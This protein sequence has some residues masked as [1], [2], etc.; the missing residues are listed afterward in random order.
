M[1]RRCEVGWFM[2]TGTA[3]VDSDICTQPCDCL[4]VKRPQPSESLLQTAVAVTQTDEI[5]SNQQKQRKSQPVPSVCTVSHTNR[6]LWATKLKIFS[7]PIWK[8][9]VRLFLHNQGFP[10]W[11]VRI[12][13][14]KSTTSCLFQPHIQ[15][16]P[17]KL[18]QQTLLINKLMSCRKPSSL[19]RSATV[20]ILILKENA[21]VIL[22]FY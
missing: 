3:R 6:L 11:R 18:G 14:Q 8:E 17:L 15:L 7:K 4:L 1:S 16:N 21:A 12:L 5:K 9:S 19:R 10:S 20:L 2:Q 13:I 22:R